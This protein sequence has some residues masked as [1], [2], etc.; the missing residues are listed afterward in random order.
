MVKLLYNKDG[1]TSTWWHSDGY[2]LNEINVLIKSA[3]EET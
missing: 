1:R 2:I 3:V